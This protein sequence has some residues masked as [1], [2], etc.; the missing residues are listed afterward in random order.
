VTVCTDV[1]APLGK[2]EARQLGRSDL[3]IVVVAHPIGNLPT[4]DVEAVGVAA[5]D[6][7]A[8]AFVSA[9]DVPDDEPSRIT[10]APP[11]ARVAAPTDADAFYDFAESRGWSDG[12]PLLLPTGQRVA[13]ALD[14][15][16]REPSEVIG[17][18]PPRR[19]VATVEIVVA[20]AVAA[21]CRPEHIP[22]VLAA[23]EGLCRPGYNLYGIQATT[24]SAAPM[25]VVFGPIAAQLGVHAGSGCLGPSV[26]ANATI[27]RAIRMVMWNVGGG[28]PG[29]LDRATHGQPGKYGMC[30]S[31]NLAE[32]PWPSLHVE[33][34]FAPDANV[35]L[36]HTI[37]GTEDLIDYSSTNADDLL[38]MLSSGLGGMA[39]NH[40]LYGG[41]SMLLLCP[42]HAQMLADAGWTRAAVQRHFVERLHVTCA[43]FPLESQETLERK[44]PRHFAEGSPATIPVFDTPDHLTIVVAGGAGPHSVF[45]PGYGD[46]TDPQMV[47][48]TTPS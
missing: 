39:V 38:T 32:S 3:S 4:A 44:R 19:A 9:I 37:M 14:Y 11:A 30:I 31:E 36:V 27:G 43:E 29:V 7:V 40:V 21:G 12:L 23:V 18:I 28:R 33:R 22:V 10:V 45:L 35:V 47:A 17:I 6:A 24:G 34:G 16:E 25:T 41:Y 1:F 20:N 46:L 26:R 42:E 15:L 13:R 8:T 5:S 2:L 48:V